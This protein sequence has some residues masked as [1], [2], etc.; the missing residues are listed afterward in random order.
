MV[1]IRPP[2][3]IR[4][5]TG[6]GT[7]KRLMFLDYAGVFVRGT[8]VFE[9]N[10]HLFNPSRDLKFNHQYCSMQTL[11]AANKLQLLHLNLW[12]VVHVYPIS[13]FSVLSSTLKQCHM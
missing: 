10:R 2:F 9:F 5:Y 8:V 13:F 7:A 1:H 3:I 11:F 4:H 12:D 6:I